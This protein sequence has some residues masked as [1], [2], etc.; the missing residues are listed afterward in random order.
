M[1]SRLRS[2]T[3]APAKPNPTAHSSGCQAR[4]LALR[5]EL[6]MAC[7]TLF[8]ACCTPCPSAEGPA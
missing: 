3:I 5:N 4:T 2:A 7:E 6:S 1:K 8:Q